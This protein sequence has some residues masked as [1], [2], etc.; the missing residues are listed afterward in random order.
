M[1]RYVGKNVFTQIKLVVRTLIWDHRHLSSP[2]VT[3]GQSAASI[4]FNRVQ[5]RLAFIPLPLAVLVP[6]SLATHPPLPAPTQPHTSQGLL[7]MAVLRRQAALYSW[8]CCAPRP[9]PPVH[10]PALIP[11]CHV[12]PGTTPRGG[13]N[14]STGAA[15]ALRPV[16]RLVF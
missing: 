11:S 4:A 15:A 14:S 10:Y 8:V 16:A 7:R 9:R 12:N 3:G 6:F 1:A 2:V 13:G 5:L